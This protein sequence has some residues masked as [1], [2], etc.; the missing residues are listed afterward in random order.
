MIVG[1]VDLT[2]LVE[3]SV[4]PLV[5]PGISREKTFAR[6]VRS[7]ATG[8]HD[9]AVVMDAVSVLGRAKTLEVLKAFNPKVPELLQAGLGVRGNV[10]Y[11]Q[12]EVGA[13]VEGA[14]MT[15]VD[16]LKAGLAENPELSVKTCFEDF[17]AGI[18]EKGPYFI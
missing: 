15:F 5:S 2:D 11:K 6:P 12:E 4:F 16:M 13:Y 7:T 3:E 10:G 8:I 18:L 17:Y 14:L 1:R 9:G